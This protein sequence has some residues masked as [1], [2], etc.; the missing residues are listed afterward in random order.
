MVLR[1]RAD[2]NVRVGDFQ[3]IDLSSGVETKFKWK[4]NF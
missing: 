2:T 1:A 3:Q 4:G